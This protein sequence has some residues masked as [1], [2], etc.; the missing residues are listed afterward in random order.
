MPISYVQH[1]KSRLVPRIPRWSNERPLTADAGAIADEEETR[2]MKR[3]G[4]GIIGTGWCGGIRAETCAAHPLV[5]S[6]HIAEIRPERLAEV[7]AKTSP[8][9]ATADYRELLGLDE[10]DAVYISATPETTH[11]PIARDC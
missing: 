11:Y 10:I 8:R 9:T 4:V 2:E 7:A 6:L 1:S 3:I 5:K